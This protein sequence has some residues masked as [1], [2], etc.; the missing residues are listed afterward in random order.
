M[1]VCRAALRVRSAKRCDVRREGRAGER[2]SV[3][4]GLLKDES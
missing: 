1:G 3:V 4:D 2:V